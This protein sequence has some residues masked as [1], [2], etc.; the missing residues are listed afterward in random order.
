M[1][2]LLHWYETSTFDASDRILFRFTAVDE[3]ALLFTPHAYKPG[4]TY[5]QAV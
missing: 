3:Q 5:L 4:H 2:D 1:R